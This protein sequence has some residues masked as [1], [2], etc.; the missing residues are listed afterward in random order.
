MSKT[1]KFEHL[2]SLIG[3]WFHQDYAIAGDTVE[4]VIESFVTKA[5]PQER[6]ATREDIQRFLGTF[7]NDRELSEAFRTTFHPDLE[8]EPWG[9]TTREFLLKI[10]ALL[11]R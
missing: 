10:D 9:L 7:T 11:S 2:D 3:G 8:D 4:E 1:A 6:A 5:K